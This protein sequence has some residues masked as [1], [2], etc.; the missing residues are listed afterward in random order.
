MSNTYVMKP[1]ILALFQK[2]AEME[3]SMQS[4]RDDTVLLRQ[5][6]KRADEVTTDFTNILA[7]FAN[8]LE[9]VE[10]SI[11]P[12]HGVTTDIQLASE[13]LQETITQLEYIISF[14]YTPKEIE[15]VV[16][17]GATSDLSDYI[18]VMY[19]AHEAMQ[20]FKEQ[21]EHTPGGRSAALSDG[22]ISEI[23]VYYGRGVSELESVYRLRVSKL[24]EIESE[25]GFAAIKQPSQNPQ[26]D[27]DILINDM[28]KIGSWFTTVQINN[29][30]TIYATV[31]SSHM[32]NL[33]KKSI[34]EDFFD[35]GQ[36]AEERGA[37][38]GAPKL[39]DGPSGGGP[40]KRGH[41]S[42][43]DNISMGARALDKIKSKTTDHFRQP[44]LGHGHRSSITALA[45]VVKGAGDNRKGYEVGSSRY[46]RSVHQFYKILD[47]EKAMTER[48]IPAALVATGFASVISTPVTDFVDLNLVM[49]QKLS[50][51]S[52]KAGYSPE[53]GYDYTLLYE[54]LDILKALK[55]NLSPMRKLLWAVTKE[56]EKYQDLVSD[57]EGA[58]TKAL[59]DITV[60][61]KAQGGRAVPND[62]TVHEV[63]SEIIGNLEKLLEYKETVI[64]L[65]SSMGSN[66]N[67]YIGELVGILYDN[68]EAKSKVYS[69]TGLQDV[70]MMNNLHYIEKHCVPSASGST[71]K[72]LEQATPQD[73]KKHVQSGFIQYR[74][75]YD[76]TWFKC[77]EAV[78][79]I[80]KGGKEH[81]LTGDKI[82]RD[83]KKMIKDKFSTFNSEFAALTSSQKQWAV[84]DT[85][86]RAALVKSHLDGLLPLYRKFL[87]RYQN[88]PFTTTPEKYIKY[89]AADVERELKALFD[90]SA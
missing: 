19:K 88:V 8:R 69:E 38:S 66:I 23:E 68:L 62:G 4:D 35:I 13:N 37:D 70:F 55:K 81:D 84:P 39:G 80:K 28:Y 17:L 54:C 36:L 29:F 33:L 75:N 41:R 30:I 76:A 50:K 82:S 89:S 26:Q 45:D 61:A 16:A 22:I 44:S 21:V 60:N 63:T 24:T 85:A 73:V 64:P 58:C 52:E 25:V 65:L 47:H 5:S 53:M 77:T 57:F 83:A 43:K 86:L 27:I 9:D 67:N 11:S 2:R 34:T 18:R 56:F 32:V 6:L 78:L 7:A 48:C 79:D 59:K 90:A 51:E 42:R 12:L 40:S 71:H 87:V 1:E 74:R 10:T 31:R 20:F 72:G 3:E 14:Y 46:A 15:D 49:V